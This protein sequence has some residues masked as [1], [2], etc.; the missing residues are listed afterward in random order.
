MPKVYL[1]RHA[2]Y[3]LNGKIFGYELLFSG[4]KGFDKEITSSLMAT[5]KVLLNLL[6]HM[7]FDKVIGKDRLA[8]INVDHD[9]LF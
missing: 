4:E 3:N 7:D 1:A 6:T 9:V 5:S 2:I 8:F